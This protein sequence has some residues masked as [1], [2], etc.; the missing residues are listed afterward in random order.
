[1]AIKHAKVLEKLK[2]NVGKCGKKGSV[3]EAIMD[4]GYS[5]SYAEN[6]SLLKTKTWE[7]LMEEYLPDES[8]AKVHKELLNN[9]EHWKARDNALDKA[10][11]LKKRYD[12]SLTIKASIS[13][14]SAEELEGAIAREVSAALDALAGEGEA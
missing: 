3:K 11:K 4:A 7:D 13:K 1:M 12:N 5:E 6:G 8:L 9:E 14:L 10:Y 2:E